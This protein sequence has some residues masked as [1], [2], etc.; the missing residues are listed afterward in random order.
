MKKNI[1][2]L[3]VIALLLVGCGGASDTSAEIVAE[4]TA[5]IHTS[6]L[7]SLSDFGFEL[8]IGGFSDFA[9]TEVAVNI[10]VKQ[11]SEKDFD[12]EK[13]LEYL[14]FIG[15][16]DNGLFY[17]IAIEPTRDGA[18]GLTD[19]VTLSGV[20]TGA[21][22]MTCHPSFTNEPGGLFGCFI[23]EFRDGR[24]IAEVEFHE[25]PMHLRDSISWAWDSV[26][27]AYIEEQCVEY[28]CYTVYLQY[29]VDHL[30]YDFIP[31]SEVTYLEFMDLIQEKGSFI[32]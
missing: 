13:L 6:E 23:N 9:G 14:N 3:F 24:A 32:K 1:V 12:T 15:L 5:P 19:R 7:S 17:L 21:V 16:V 27:T 25:T 29:V 10:K 18:P 2:F 26:V 31:L 8:P 22:H 4:V 28:V 20:F 30:G 11:G